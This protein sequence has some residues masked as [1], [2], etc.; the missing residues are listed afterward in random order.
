[1]NLVY[2]L[3]SGFVR[4]PGFVDNIQSESTHSNIKISWSAPITSSGEVMGVDRYIVQYT[5]GQQ[6]TN[7]FAL[8]VRQSEETYLEVS[9]LNPYTSAFFTIMA[10]YQ[11]MIGPEVCIGVSTGN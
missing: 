5:F 9:N 11:D 1:M 6:E 2:H 10:E 3:S 8:I 4:P 7:Q